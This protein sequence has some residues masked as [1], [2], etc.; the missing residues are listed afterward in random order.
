MASMLCISQKDILFARNTKV[1]VDL[2]DG[3]FRSYEA[4]DWI[5]DEASCDPTTFNHIRKI[6]LGC[7][8]DKGETNSFWMWSVKIK[9][10]MRVKGFAV[11]KTRGGKIFWWDPIRI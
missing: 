10:S 7:I 6:D 3:L 1:L 9:M 5:V 8:H 11:T 4:D 2:I